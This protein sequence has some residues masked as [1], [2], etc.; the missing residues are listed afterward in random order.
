MR[1]LTDA[2]MTRSL[3]SRLRDSGHDV[4]SVPEWSPHADDRE[5]LE[6]ARA[7]HRV[8]VTQD[9]WFGNRRLHQVGFGYGVIIVRPKSLTPREVI[10]LVEEAVRDYGDGLFEKLTVL[11]RNRARMNDF[12]A[13][14][15]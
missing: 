9:L 1:L 7:E 8:L 6:V 10:E 14:H 4:L 12:S 5:I 3:T 13:S 2:N 11:D 15:A